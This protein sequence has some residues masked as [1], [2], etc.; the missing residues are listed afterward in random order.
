MS[1]SITTSTTKTT[2]STSTVSSTM[3]STVK[4]QLT[5]AY[6]H[7][8]NH[9]SVSTTILER[10]IFVL[11]ERFEYLK[12]TFGCAHIETLTVLRELILLHWTHVTKESRAH[13]VKMLLETTILIITKEKNSR[14]LHEAAKKIAGIYLRCE[15]HEEGRVMLREIHR[16]I[17]CRSYSSSEKCGFKIDHS[18]GKE[19]YVFL[20]T[21]EQLIQGSVSISY[22]NIMADLLTETILFESYTR[23]VK[24]EKN[25]EV[26]LTAGARLFVFLH[27]SAWKEQSIVIRDEL[28]KIFT[29]KWGTIV[30]AQGDITVL[31]VTS[32]LMVLSDE[33]SH[34]H[35]GKAAC[36]SSNNKVRELLVEGDYIRAY[37]VASCAFK[38][39]EHL[40]AYHHLQN[41]GYGFKLSSLMALRGMKSLVKPVDPDTHAKMLDLSRKIISEVLKACKDSK[42][43]FVRLKLSELNELVGLLGEQQNYADLEVSKQKFYFDLLLTFS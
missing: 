43:N 13:V 4:Q 35:I 6:I 8:C 1:K 39:I 20:V 32:L 3:I 25:I 17:V 9:G 24:S 27:K 5:K 21:F 18:V 36:K 41:V 10:A 12:V 34:L 30:K 42:I 11:T 28:I 31:F 19:S 16:Q 23:C 29:K 2:T 14:T 15:L 33:T 7:V 22:S 38:F 26:V 40:G 37:G